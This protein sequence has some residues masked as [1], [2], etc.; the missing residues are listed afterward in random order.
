M[1]G[2]HIHA[3]LM[4]MIPQNAHCLITGK[5]GPYP[6]RVSVATKDG[7]PEPRPVQTPVRVHV[8]QFP[9]RSRSFQSQERLRIVVDDVSNG[10][11]RDDLEQIRRQS[12]EESPDTF[13]SDGLHS[14]IH[15]ARVSWRVDCCPLALQS[16]TEEIERV[17][18]AGP[19]SSTKSPY[20]CC[21][22]VSWSRVVLVTSASFSIG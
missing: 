9:I 15:K 12:L 21:H 17:Y 14:D 8:F 20:T 16:S 7:F 5:Y 11:R 10:H 1:P 18:H 19:E 2:Y 13:S 4:Q 3:D 6:G 22:E